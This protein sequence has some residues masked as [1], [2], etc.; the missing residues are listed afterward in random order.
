MF[1][2]VSL[3][4]HT[5]FKWM[6]RYQASA[7]FDDKLILRIGTERIEKQ[8]TNLR[9]QNTP[10]RVK[11]GNN[12]FIQWIVE[13]VSQTYILIKMSLTSVPL[14]HRHWLQP[15]HV[16]VCHHINM[17]NV[18]IKMTTFGDSVSKALSILSQ[19]WHLVCTLCG[20]QYIF[21]GL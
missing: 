20:F 21:S 5:W 18:S 3:L 11:C 13:S 1:L 8:W 2:E 14:Y 16:H 17:L 15:V 6:T 12:V 10:R 19:N 7:G 9:I 4:Q